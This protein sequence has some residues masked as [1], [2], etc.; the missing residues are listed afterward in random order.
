MNADQISFMDGCAGSGDPM[1]TVRTEDMPDS[2]C[3]ASMDR[4]EGLPV[5][6]AARAG[7]GVTVVRGFLHR[8]PECDEE[9][10][11]VIHHLAV[12]LPGGHWLHVFDRGETGG[13]VKAPGVARVQ[14]G[15]RDVRALTLGPGC[16]LILITHEDGG[17]YAIPVRDTPDREDALNVS[18]A[19][20][21]YADLGFKVTIS[22][23]G[24]HRVGFRF[25]HDMFE[26]LYVNHPEWMASKCRFAVYPQVVSLDERVRML[27]HA[28]HNPESQPLEADHAGELLGLAR[29]AL[30]HHPEA[31][32]TLDATS[33]DGDGFRRLSTRLA[34]WA[35]VDPKAGTQVTVIPP[36]DAYPRP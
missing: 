10:G 21:D 6:V 25:L 33:L 22:V 13:C 32:I 29:T 18:M 9:N 34:K 7:D 19:L 36:D 28:I 14:P 17:V 31:H 3:F 11:P 26:P 20:A 15:W 12:P 4:A 24:V 2:I 16:A 30:R 23:R 8:C 27:G 35:H 5:E 1:L